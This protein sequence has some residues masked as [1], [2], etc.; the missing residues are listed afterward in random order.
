MFFRTGAHAKLP[1]ESFRIGLEVSFCVVT[2]DTTRKPLAIELEAQE[3]GTVA[4]SMRHTG[5]PRFEVHDV[6]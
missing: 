1:V 3:E 6:A 4:K 5:D 2:D